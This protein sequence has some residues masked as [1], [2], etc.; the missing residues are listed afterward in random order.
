MTITEF[1]QF[2]ANVLKHQREKQELS[3]YQMAEISGIKQPHINRIES[4]KHNIRI[5]TIKR[6]ADALDCEITFAVFKE[7]GR[8]NSGGGKLKNRILNQ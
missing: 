8:L 3:Q 1:R 4:G 5:D 7:K 2:I 6:Y